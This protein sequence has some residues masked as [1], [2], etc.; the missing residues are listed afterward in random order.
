MLVALAF[1]RSSLG[2]AGVSQGQCAEGVPCSTAWA[3]DTEKPCFKKNFFFQEATWTS[4]L[5]LFLLRLFSFNS[6]GLQEPECTVLQSGFAIIAT[7]AGRQPSGPWG[8][9]STIWSAEIFPLSMTKR[10]SRVKCS[11]GKGSLQS[12]SISSDGVWP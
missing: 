7:M 5:C 4:L 1:N 11:S 6:L 9:C 3:A 8:F 12:A 2:R 10:S